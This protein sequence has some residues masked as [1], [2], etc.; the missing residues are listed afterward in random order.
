MACGGMIFIKN[1]QK[2]HIILLQLI[3]FMLLDSLNI[4]GSK[5]QQDC[6]FQGKA[7]NVPTA[8]KVYEVVIL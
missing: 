3:C 6:S 5:T 7:L 2:M 4:Q 8:F 1:F